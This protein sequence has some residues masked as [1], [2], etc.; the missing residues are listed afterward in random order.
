[1]SDLRFAR[2]AFTLIELLVVI[3][4]IAILIGLLLPA[5]QKVREAAARSTCQ[6]NLK[7]IG[8]AM[9]NYEG[10]NMKFPPGLNLPIS[11]QSGAVFPTNAL[12]TSGKIAQPPL[13]NTFQ[14]WLTIILPFMEQDN[15]YRGFDLTQRDYAN[16]NLAANV[17]APA[18]NNIK[19]YVCPSDFVPTE[20]VT[21][22]TGGITYTF[23]LNS[24]FAN[25]GTRSWFIANATFDGVFQINSKTGINS[26][27][28]GTSN[29]LMVGERN[30]KDLVFTDLPNR[31]GWAWAN[32][33]APQ[34]LFCGTVVP[35]NYTIPA[36]TTLTT[37]L[38]DARLNAF[39][40]QHPGGA[41]FLLCDGSV[42]FL[43]LTSTGDLPTLQL[44]ARP[45][46]G[47]V[48]TLP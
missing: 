18:A 8:L 10:V 13:A 4:I 43:A 29:T 46:D 41:N 2:K 42:R 12:V 30:S 22:A 34:D 31:R 16:S 47:Q 48:V 9:H 27:T 11:S 1:M 21:F 15:I 32:Y 25:A 7:Q 44:L 37:A 23:G 14:S 20:K 5:V 36:G 45:A 28:D 24:Y 17:N 40:S 39:G 26:I 3:A 19:T 38:S 33:L 35:V 6:N